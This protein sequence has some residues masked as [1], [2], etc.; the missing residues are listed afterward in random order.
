[1]G[2]GKRKGWLRQNLF[3]FQNLPAYP[4]AITAEV[5]EEEEERG[6]GEARG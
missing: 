4:A 6:L 1:M 5:P 2:E 3:A